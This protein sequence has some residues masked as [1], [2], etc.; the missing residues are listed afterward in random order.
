M[1]EKEILKA[2]D[3]KELRIAYFAHDFPLFFAYHF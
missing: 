1:N 2:L 3:D